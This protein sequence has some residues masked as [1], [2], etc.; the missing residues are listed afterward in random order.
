MGYSA[1]CMLTM[2][3]LADNLNIDNLVKNTSALLLQMR[4]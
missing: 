3:F 2:L 1:P 4:A